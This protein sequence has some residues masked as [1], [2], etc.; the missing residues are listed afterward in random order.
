M[1]GFE[2]TVLPEKAPLLGVRFSDDTVF[3]LIAS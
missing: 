1:T 2:E 3:F